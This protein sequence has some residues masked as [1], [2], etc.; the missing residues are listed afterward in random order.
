M[1]KRNEFDRYNNETPK[2]RAVHGQ[3]QKTYSRQINSGRS[4][5][6]KHF[7]VIFCGKCRDYFHTE[8]DNPYCEECGSRWEAPPDGLK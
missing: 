6:F 1:I 5:T 8:M 2:N 7:K 3:V 4:F